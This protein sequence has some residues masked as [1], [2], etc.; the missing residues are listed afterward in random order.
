[1]AVVRWNLKFIC[2]FKFNKINES[3]T[4]FVIL[5]LS[6]FLDDVAINLIG[7]MIFR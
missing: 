7:S 2:E 3:L 1:M 6:S 5:I 4:I